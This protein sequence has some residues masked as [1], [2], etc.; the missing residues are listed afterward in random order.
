MATYREIHGKAVKSLDTDPSVATDAGQIWYNTTSST[1]K[2]IVNLEAWSSG[3][4]FINAREQGAGLGILTAAVYAG[5]QTPGGVQTVAEEYNGSGWAV[6]GALNTGR[7]DFGNASAGTQTAGLVFGGQEPGQSNKA[8]EYNGTAW[9]AGGTLSTARHLIAG[10]GIQTA[11]VAAGGN[12]EPPAPAFT[13]SEEYGGTS[14]TAGGTLNTGRQSAAGGGT[15][16][17]GIMFS[18]YTTTVVA[19]TEDYDGTSWTNANAMVTATYMGGGD[20]DQTAAIAFGGYTPPATTAT[21][22]MMVQTGLR[23]QLL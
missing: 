8:E 4:P 1:F 11:A 18:G 23:A 5:G 6:G 22:I 15:L 19:N 20:G 10:F 14:W 2:S 13:G 3:S 17:A 12:A 7:K 9:T 21:Q 16:T